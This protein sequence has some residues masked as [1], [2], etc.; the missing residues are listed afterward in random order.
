MV[1]FA[2][3]AFRFFAIGLIPE[4]VPFAPAVGAPTELTGVF[5]LPN[6]RER[7]GS[8]ISLPKIVTPP[9]CLERL[10]FKAF[11][12]FSLRVRSLRNRVAILL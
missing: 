9:R 11:L 12:C 3:L 5:F 8:V 10:V 7:L 4:I 6:G 1:T 2:F